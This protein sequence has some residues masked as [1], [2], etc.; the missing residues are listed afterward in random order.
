MFRNPKS[1][2][3]GSR[4]FVAEAFDCVNCEVTKS[5]PQ[6]GNDVVLDI[7][8]L[9]PPNYG[10]WSGIKQFSMHDVISVFRLMEV[11]RD[12]WDDIYMRLS[13]FHSTLMDERAKQ[14]ARAAKNK[15]SKK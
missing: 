6:F 3:A 12:L 1:F 11:H 7:Y 13:H 10:E 8:E 5:Q 9:L 14:Q 4:V 15:A 2:P